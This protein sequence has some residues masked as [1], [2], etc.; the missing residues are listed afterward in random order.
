M[1]PSDIGPY[2][3]TVITTRKTDVE[4]TD[5]FGVFGLFLGVIGACT[6]SFIIF[7]IGLAIWEHIGPI[8]VIGLLVFMFGLYGY[9]RTGGAKERAIILRRLSG[10]PKEQ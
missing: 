1:G 7:F 10:I 3:E 2:A 9:Y 4:T 8:T 5:N 6:A